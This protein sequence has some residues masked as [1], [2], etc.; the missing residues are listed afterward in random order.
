MPIL[1]Y[2]KPQNFT[3]FVDAQTVSLDF[4]GTS[5][6]MLDAVQRDHGFGNAF[7]WAAWLKPDQIAGDPTGDIFQHIMQLGPSEGAAGADRLDFFMDNSASGRMKVQLHSAG[8]GT[9]KSYRWGGVFTIGEWT[10]VLITWDGTDLNG[11]FDGQFQVAG[12]Q[13]DNALTVANVNRITGVG[14]LDATSGFYWDGRI[15]SIAM[16]DTNIDSAAGAIYNG[17]SSAFD[18]KTN[19]GQYTFASNLLPWWRFGHDS[20]TVGKDFGTGPVAIDIPGIGI[21]S[22]DIVTDA[23]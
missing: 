17:G 11:Y 21:T 20:D 23:P 6:R 16:W 18:L 10:H 13:T 7:S 12:K 2:N 1:L 3:R 9:E 8:G 4:N 5:E 14:R 19:K 22:A 15:H